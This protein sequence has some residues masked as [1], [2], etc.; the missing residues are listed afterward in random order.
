[1]EHESIFLWC[2]GN[3]G[4]DKFISGNIHVG[5]LGASEVLVEFTCVLVTVGETNLTSIDGDVSTNCEV[6]GHEGVSW[7]VLVEKNV[8]L[9]EGSLR[10]STVLLLGFHEHH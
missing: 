8:S 4:L 10:N 2:D 3:L 9:E 7:V 5:S 1:L 6:L